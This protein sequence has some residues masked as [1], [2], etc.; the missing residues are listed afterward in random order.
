MKRIIGR[1]AW[2]MMGWFALGSLPALSFGQGNVFNPY[3]NSG[4]PD[5]RE[6]AIPMYSNNPALPGQARIQAM[7]LGERPISR[8]NQ[9]EQ[10][11]D[12]F[13]EPAEPGVKRGASAPGVPYYRTF[14]QYDEQYNRVYKPNNTKADQEFAARAKRREQA[15][16]E[17]LKEADPAKRARLLRQID[18]DSLT[19][20]RPKAASRGTANA[21]SASNKAAT[22]RVADAPA[23]GDTAPPPPPP[24]ASS[25]APA[26]EVPYPIGIGRSPSGS[27]PA[28]RPSRPRT[29]TPSPAPAAPV[30]DPR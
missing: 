12:R 26:G 24:P 6:F 22:P 9:F 23:T 11:F 20:P 19:A 10:Y 7:P 2:L 21:K 28:P 18:Q 27:A 29:S 15:Y 30:P 25:S 16:A 1:N 5:Y 8:A 14:R 3:G 13:D 17:A 4:Y